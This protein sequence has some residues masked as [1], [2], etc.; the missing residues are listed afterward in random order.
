MSGYK[1]K[2]ILIGRYPVKNLLIPQIVKNQLE[3]DHSFTRGVEILTKDVEY[4]P[5]EVATLSIWNLNMPIWN[6]K[7]L[8]RFAFIRSTFYK[9]AA[10]VILIFDLTSRETF[11]EVKN[12]FTEIKQITGHRPLLLIGNTF[13]PLKKEDEK[14]FREKAREFAKSEDGFYIETSPKSIE[15]VDDAISK[16]TRRI[17]DLRSR[18]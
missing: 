10:G 15:I 2:V 6:L 4:R 12:W 16:L 9:G 1:L 11:I 14:L 7:M 18:K 5:N 8:Q 17:I 13:N 3:A